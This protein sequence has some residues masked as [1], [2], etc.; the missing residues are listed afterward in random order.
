MNTAA[1]GRY[2]RKDRR[3]QHDSHC[4]YCGANYGIVKGEPRA[5]RT[6][7]CL[8]CGTKQCMVNG[9]GNG[10]CSVCYH[11]LLEGWAGSACGQA[12]SYKGCKQH[13]VARGRGRKRVCLAHL[14]RQQPDFMVSTEKNRDTGWVL[15]PDAEVP[16]L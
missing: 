12:C 9:L 11:G 7:T 15:L 4:L 13:A 16:A 5:C 6:T 3:V 1:Q 14:G 8:A 10:Q 2:V